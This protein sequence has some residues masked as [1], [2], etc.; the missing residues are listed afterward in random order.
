MQ[1]ILE[2]DSKLR[3][4]VKECTNTTR[5]YKHGE[6]GHQGDV[7]VHPIKS[8]PSAW[9]VLVG[10]H[11]QVALGNTMGSRHIAEGNVKVYWPKSKDEAGKT[12]PIA[13]FKNRKTPISDVERKSCLGPVV[14]SDGPW[15]LEHP[16]HAHC[17][18]PA[19]TYLVTYQFDEM[20][21]INV[22]D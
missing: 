6:T 2:L 4:A 3:E 17:Q 15:T 12:C 14:V 9:D 11:T 22:R 19:G 1:T 20:T 16:E 8:K 7:Y 10:E 21:R 5:V 18:F 13:L